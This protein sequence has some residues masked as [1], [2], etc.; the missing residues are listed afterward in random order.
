MGH[1]MVMKR[2]PTSDAAGGGLVL[3][4][5]HSTEDKVGVEGVGNESR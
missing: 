4:Y 2:A 3:V 5:L 1:G